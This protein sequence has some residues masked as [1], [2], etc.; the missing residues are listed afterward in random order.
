MSIPPEVLAAKEALMRPL[1]ASRL[2]TGVDFGVRDEENPDPEDIALRVFVATGDDIPFEVQAVTANFP[3]PVM[4]V[5]RTFTLTQVSLPDQSRKR[6][7]LGGVSVFSS[8]LAAQAQPT[9]GTLGAI[10][11]DSLDPTTFY[12]LSNHHVLCADLGRGQGDEIIQPEPPF[13]S[14]PGDRVGV[15]HDWAFPEGEPEGSI[16]AA[17]FRL[18]TDSIPEVEEVGPV[19]GSVEPKLGMLVSKRG[20][21]TGLT[22][23]VIVSTGGDYSLAYP[24][25]PA[26]GAP[27]S[28]W[29]TL[30][31]QIQVR[32]DFPQSI[33]FGE[34][35]DSGAVV[36]D[37]QSRVVGL[38]WGGG[39]TSPGDP[40]RFGL[41]TPA[42][43]VEFALPITF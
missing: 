28:V 36:L 27:P 25:L 5:Q 7:V 13:G 8:R 15:L 35:G 17:I 2:I 14:I 20:R 9:A 24:R 31:N 33:V 38:Y 12:G 42:A 1:L 11:V 40:L 6:P 16:D 43:S 3:F 37:S 4:F 39:F 29:R 23:G 34:S 18:E 22:F 21:T 10:V 26:V 41:V 30:T 19:F 32:A